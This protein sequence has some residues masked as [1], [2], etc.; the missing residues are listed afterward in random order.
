MI[1]P[2]FGRMNF[3]YHIVSLDVI[4]AT[5]ILIILRIQKISPPKAFP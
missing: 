1:M 3:H 4:Y 2:V 5:N